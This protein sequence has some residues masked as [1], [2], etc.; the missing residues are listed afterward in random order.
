MTTPIPKVYRGSVRPVGW[1]IYTDLDAGTPRLLPDNSV[2]VLTITRGR[3]RLTKRSDSG[4]GS[5]L[6]FVGDEA[7]DSPATVRWTPTKEESRMFGVGRAHVELEYWSAGT[8]LP[9]LPPDAALDFVNGRNTD[10]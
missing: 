6:L 10:A 1:S 8:Q 5:L 7:T 3:K 9:L 4:D 2:A